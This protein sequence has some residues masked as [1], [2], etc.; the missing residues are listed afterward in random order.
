VDQGLM[1]LQH[2]EEQY[3]KQEDVWRLDETMGI[4]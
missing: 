2:L 3:K 1:D 4:Q